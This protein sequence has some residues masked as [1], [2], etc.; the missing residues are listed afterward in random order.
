MILFQFLRKIVEKII[1]ENV[2]I[3]SSTKKFQNGI[4][5]F[6]KFILLQKAIIK[7]KENCKIFW[8]DLLSKGLMAYLHVFIMTEQI[9]TKLVEDFFKSLDSLL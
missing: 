5:F 4:T 2:L 3:G 1:R 9:S 8:K 7:N 6:M